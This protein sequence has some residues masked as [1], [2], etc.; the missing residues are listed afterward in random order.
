LEFGLLLSIATEAVF[1]C[2]Q[3][4]K[5]K[6]NSFI[7]LHCYLLEFGLLLSMATEAVFLCLQLFFIFS[8]RSILLL[9][10]IVIYWS[11]AYFYPWQQKQFN[12][13]SGHGTFVGYKIM[14]FFQILMKCA[15]LFL[16][17]SL[18][19]DHVMRSKFI[20]RVDV[21]TM[22]LFMETIHPVSPLWCFMQDIIFIFNN[23]KHSGTL[24]PK[25]MTCL[26]FDYEDIGSAW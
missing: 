20:G 14:T 23:S 10:C 12:L 7:V 4:F 17:W 19:V 9:F 24:Q 5:F 2:F 6:I 11:L 3:L 1:L 8:L 26:I 21:F 22:V 13:I 16:K 18:L 25:G 15:V